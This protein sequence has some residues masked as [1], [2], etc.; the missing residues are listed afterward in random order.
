LLANYYKNKPDH[1]FELIIV[2][3]RYETE[4]EAF[5]DET[6]AIELGCPNLV[7]ECRAGKFLDIRGNRAA[8][9]ILKLEGEEEKRKEIITKVLKQNKYFD[10]SIWEC[11]RCFVRVKTHNSLTRHMKETVCSKKYY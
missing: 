1:H 2:G 3:G 10:D 11:T 9:E 5:A 4:P 7:T 6:V 8:L